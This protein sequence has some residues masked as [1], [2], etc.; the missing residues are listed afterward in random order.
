MAWRVAKCL[1][2]LRQQVNAKWPGRSKASD[3]L[4]GDAAHASRKSDHN[5]W[6]KDGSMG[7]VTAL[8]ITHDP[9]HGCDA[10]KIA[11]AVKSD[12][13]VKY[14]I[15][16]RRIWNPS[17]SKSWRA[18]SGANPHT[19]HVHISVK[20]DKAH[21]DSTA[22]WPIDGLSAAPDPQAPLPETR[23][24]LKRGAKGAEVRTLQTWLNSRGASPLL[25]VDG[26]FGPK[27]ERAVKT[28]QAQNS[29]VADGIVGPYTWAALEANPAPEPNLGLSGPIR[30][31]TENWPAYAKRYFRGLGYSDL[32]AAAL[33]AG[34]IWESGGNQKTP[35]T[36]I[37]DAVGDGG[38]SIGAGQW[39][40]PRNAALKDYA[41]SLGKPWTDPGAQLAF[42]ARELKT[43][44]KRAD[45]ALRA[46][47]T[48]E[49]ANAAAISYWR[50]GVP[51]ADKRLAILR[52][53]L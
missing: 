2:T 46:A 35:M 20:P 22:L 38:N 29:L 17:I 43:T 4:I 51:H 5:P 13:R 30:E 44:E 1:E 24:L 40:G 37:W 34:L 32:A 48:A 14:L 12:P 11:E 28:F 33:A 7:V 39:N 10:G 53:L 36:I 18:Y 26:D 16:N 25:V 21:Y 27:T 3:G 49:E 52:T 45:A 9:A 42:M 23:P 8:D 31:Q 41:F 47:G 19:K 50:P 15:W 6:V